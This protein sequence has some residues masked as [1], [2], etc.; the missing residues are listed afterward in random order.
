MKKILV[1][2]FYFLAFSILVN[3]QENNIKKYISKVGI[4]FSSLGTDDVFYVENVVGDG[5]YKSRNIYAFGFNYTLELNKWI[6]LET[7]I[8]YSKH[9]I[10]IT[11]AYTG[12]EV[13][14]YKT[15]FALL[16]IPVTAR[17]NFLKYFFIN[18]GF[19]I[20]IDV[21]S[22]HHVNEQ[23]GIGAILGIAA[24]CDLNPKISVFLNPYSKIHSLI[25]LV[26]NRF[27]QKVLESGFR[28]GLM[29]KIK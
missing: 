4:T 1:I 26:E 10:T 28:F 11:P 29:Y 13:Q 15:N 5:S 12:I 8:E 7:G 21:S 9:N 19:I 22:N 2:I 20:D 23:T 14:P 3:A 16:N 17:I 18:G 6:E 24:K 27:N 25:P